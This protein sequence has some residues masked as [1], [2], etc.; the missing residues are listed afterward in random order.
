MAE[1]RT[2]AGAGA[3]QTRRI[4]VGS[5]MYAAPLRAVQGGGEL[6]CWQRLAPGRVDLG[7]GTGHAPASVDCRAARGRAGV[8]RLRRTTCAI[9][10]A[11]CPAPKP[12][13]WRGRFRSRRRSASAR[14]QPAECTAGNELGWLRPA[15]HF[16]GDPKHI[17]AA[18]D[19]YRS[20]SPRSRRCGHGGLRR[21]ATA[22]ALRH[23]GALR[24]CKPHPGPGR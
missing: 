18:F 12:M 7:V 16:D 9:L 17:E 23:I 10:R 6:T 5:G 2:G 13:C 24:V 11:I 21:T 20:A 19:A 1:S 14:C 8:R 3:A 22:E 15:A 4:R